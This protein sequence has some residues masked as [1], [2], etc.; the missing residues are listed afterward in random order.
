MASSKV[1]RP[2]ASEYA[3]HAKIYLDLV[4][5]D[6]AVSA[7]R[8]Q[9]GQTLALFDGVDDRHASEWS[10]EPGKWTLKQVLGHMIDTERIFAYRALRVARGDR[11]PLPGFEQDEYVATADSNARPLA[12]L[13][14][15]F[16][17]VRAGTLALVDGLPE[18]AWS[19]RGTVSGRELSVRGIVFTAAGHERHHFELLKERYGLGTRR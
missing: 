7:L 8:Q 6:D 13:T 5:G 10:Y 14:E 12:D 17:I 18:E 4:P 3:P 11:T 15:E 1:G 19:R 2:E 9:I 16:R